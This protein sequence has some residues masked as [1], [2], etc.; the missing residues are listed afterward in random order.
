MLPQRFQRPSG[1]DVTEAFVNSIGI[2][3]GREA[4]D[5]VLNFRDWAARVAVERT[6]HPSQKVR[7][8][9]DKTIELRLKVLRFNSNH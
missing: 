4:T 7:H 3:A 1:F 6:W 8:R 2:C 9:A 5:V